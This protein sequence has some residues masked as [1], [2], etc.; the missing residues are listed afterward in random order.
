MGLTLIKNNRPKVSEC[1]ECEERTDLNEDSVLTG[2]CNPLGQRP[3]MGGGGSGSG[4]KDVKMMMMSV[5]YLS[6]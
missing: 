6:F 3:G 4:R 5:Q 1:E 2:Q